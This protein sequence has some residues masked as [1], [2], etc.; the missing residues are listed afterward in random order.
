MKLKTNFSIEDIEHLIMKYFGFDNYKSEDVI[1]NLHYANSQINCF[2][3]EIISKRTAYTTEI[4][5]ILKPSTYKKRDLFGA[6]DSALI[7]TEVTNP[8][9]LDLIIADLNELHLANIQ[10]LKDNEDNLD[11]I[12]I[13]VRARIDKIS[14]EERDI[15]LQYTLA[16]FTNPDRPLFESK[17][18]KKR[19]EYQITKAYF[20]LDQ[21]ATVADKFVR[22]FREFF[23]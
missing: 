18:H 3:G 12:N 13:C 6:Y 17:H 20:H 15:L 22:C 11:R 9:K 16:D 19:I 7:P 4:K 8:D 21:R 10:T 14:Q 5:N 23:V 2:L 1:H